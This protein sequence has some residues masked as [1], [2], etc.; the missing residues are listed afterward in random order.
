MADCNYITTI[1]ST[2]CLADSV[3]KLNSNFNNIETG[4]STATA[5]FNRLNAQFGEFTPGLVS[6]DESIIY[7]A[8]FTEAYNPLTTKNLTIPGYTFDRILNTVDYNCNARGV[9]ITGPG[10]NNGY[11]KLNTLTGVITVPPGVYDI[12]AEASLMGCE[13]HVA[14]LVYADKNT[15]TP[16]DVLF[17]GSAEYTEQGG[18]LWAPT[19]GKMRGRA[20]FNRATPLKIKHYGANGSNPIRRGRTFA[21]DGVSVDQTNFFGDTPLAYYS[22][23]NIQK[24]KDV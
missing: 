2:D 9:R 16:D 5:F 12:D 21:D 17:H 4:I 20:V 19:W 24:I 11:Y 14:N 7:F 15:N 6:L 10:A 23:F 18:A 3:P 8:R 1:N 13:A 22:F